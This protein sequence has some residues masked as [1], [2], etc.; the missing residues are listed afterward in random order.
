MRARSRNI[1]GVFT[2]LIRQVGQVKVRD[3]SESAIDMER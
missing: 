1:A 2:T 3:G